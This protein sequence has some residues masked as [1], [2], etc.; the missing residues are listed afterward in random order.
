M[1]IKIL[2]EK[3]NEIKEWDENK[4]KQNKDYIERL[5]EIVN[6]IIEKGKSL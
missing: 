1:E 3:L 5:F 4:K 2:S 6:Q